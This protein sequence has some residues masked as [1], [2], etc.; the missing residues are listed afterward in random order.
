MYSI[1]SKILFYNILLLTI[2][3]VLKHDPKAATN[4]TC[5]SSTLESIPSDL[6]V[7]AIAH[8][9]TQPP[10]ASWKLKPFS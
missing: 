8:L 6:W 5:P 10:K 9:S 4:E 1:N 2:L 7:T 3:M